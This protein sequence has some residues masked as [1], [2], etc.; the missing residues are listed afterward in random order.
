VILHPI[1]YIRNWR[2][3]RR[4]KREQE[5]TADRAARVTANA[6]VWM[7]V[8]TVLLF[9][10]NG[11]TVFILSIQLKEMH[12]G[13]IDTHALAK[14]SENAA[15]AA[16]DQADAAQQFSDTAEDINGRMQEAVD[17]L[18]A[19]AENANTSV[20]ATQ[21]ALRLEQRPW[22]FINA[23]DLK[24]PTLNDPLVVEY[25]IKN[26]GRTPATMLKDS[27]IS[28]AISLS[29]MNHLTDAVANTPFNTGL[30]FPGTV[31]GPSVI[32]SSTMSGSPPHF[33][34]PTEIAAYS[35]KPP[36]LWVYVYGRLIYSDAFGVKH[37]TSYCQVSNGTAI[38]QSCVE[39]V[40]PTYAN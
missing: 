22:V 28:M 23:M 21:N 15:D 17:Q 12:E 39:G 13:G 2:E 31:Y 36:A 3:E 5:T 7:A 8:F 19:A 10:L 4:A 14:A 16:S 6:T 29:P 27:K 38:F 40:Y 33:L 35:A 25:S 1:T 32:S 26:E 37:T 20:R 24:P 18:Q 34:G 11:I 9:V 30:I